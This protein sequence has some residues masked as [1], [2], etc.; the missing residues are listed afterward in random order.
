[1][2]HQFSSEDSEKCVSLPLPS[3]TCKTESERGGDPI[4]ASENMDSETFPQDIANQVVAWI[5][6]GKTLRAFC[7]QEGKPAYTTI[8]AW[9]KKDAD[10]AER[11]ARARDSGHDSIADECLE[12][13]DT[14]KDANLGKAQVW[15]RLQL[16]AKWNPKKY[17]DKVDMNLGGQTDNPIKAAITVEF[18]NPKP[19]S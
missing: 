13:I 12:I 10:F 16:L 9:M 15:T 8:Y 7:R 2:W 19:K 6:E 5:A 1:M 18:V 11:I 14:A 17:G 4:S 3:N